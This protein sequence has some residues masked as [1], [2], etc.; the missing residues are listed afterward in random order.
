ML[1]PFDDYPLH[2]T[3][4]PI[5]HVAGQSPDRYDRYAF[6]GY[7]RTGTALFF[8]ATLGTYPNLDIVDGAFSVVRGGEQVSV[9][10]SGRAPLDR[11]RTTVGPLRVEVVEPMRKLRV[12]LDGD[13]G[14]LGADLLFT[15]RTAAIEEPRSTLVVDASTVFDHTR[16]AQWGSWEGQLTIDGTTI[17]VTPSVLGSRERSWGVFPLDGRA[18]DR[19]PSRRAPQAFSLR[20]PLNFDDCAV[21]VSID[22]H[23]DGRRWHGFGAIVPRFLD[24]EQEPDDLVAE[25]ITMRAVEYVVD[26]EPGTRRSAMAS[27]ILEPFAG[28]THIIRLEPRLTFHQAGLGHAHP[29]WGHGR[30]HGEAAT[31]SFRWT[32]DQLDPQDPVNLHVQQLVT[33]RWAGRTGVGVLEQRALGNHDP[34]GLSGLYD[35]AP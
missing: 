8:A 23:G 32:L 27:I 19:P 3:S 4:Q 17:D 9:L 21:H 20:S 35:G 28:E 15:A 25:P 2:Q 31:T 22:E 7:S 14:P 34:S 11:T 12:R 10:S 33:A 18:G 30:W 24:D 5:L 26:W 16:V 6:T 1:H 29:E 13:A